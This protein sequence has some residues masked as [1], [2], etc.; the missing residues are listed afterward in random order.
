MSRDDKYLWRTLPD[1]RRQVSWR[2]WVLV[3]VIPVCFAGAALL[4]AL[5]TLYQQQAMA[6]TEGEVVKVYEWDSDNPLDEG[7]KVYSPV[8]RYTWTDGTQTE[9][10]AGVSSSLWNF[11]IGTKRQIRYWSDRKDN[12]VLVDPTEWL[13]ARVLAVIAACALVP[14][15]IGTFLIRRWISRGTVA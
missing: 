1:G 13:I 5:I 10:T 15:L 9:A 6:V 14:A 2:T 12:V 3:W 7:P 4:F 8:W 11:P